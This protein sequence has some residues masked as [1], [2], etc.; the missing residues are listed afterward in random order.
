ILMAAL[1]VFAIIQLGIVNECSTEIAEGWLPSTRYLGDFRAASEQLRSR[2]FQHNI[3]TDAAELA[4]LEKKMDETRQEADDALKNYEKILSGEEDRKLFSEMKQSWTAYLE[5]HE[6][7]FLAASRANDSKKASEVLDGD[8]KKQFDALRE[9]VDKV[10]QFNIAGGTAASA[11]GDELFAS[12]RTMT[13]GAILVALV[14]STSLATWLSRNISRGVMA[15][16]MAARQIAQTDLPQLASCSQSIAEGDLTKN[17]AVTCQPVQVKSNDEIGDMARSFNDM[18]ARLRETGDAFGKMTANLRGTIGTVASAAVSLTEASQQLAAASEQSGAAA[19]QIATTIQEVAKGNQDQSASVQETTASVDQLGRAID[20]IAKGSQN[21]SRAVEH[22]AASVTQL[23]DSI[24][25]ANT[26]SKG[27][28]AAG[29]EVTSAARNGAKSVQS[30]AEGITAIKESTALAASKIQE[31]GA[32]SDQIGSI[33]ETIDDIAEQTNLL[34][35]NAAIEAARA[36]EHG[37]GFAVV[38]DEVRKLAERSSKSTKEIAELIGQVQKATHEAV[39]AMEQGGK[40]VEHGALQSRESADAISSVLAAVEKTNLEVSRI[41]GALLEMETA[42]GQVVAQMDSVSSVVEETSVFTKEM[43]ASSGQVTGAIEKIAAVSEQTS[44]S[45]EEVSASAEEMSAQV[46]EMVAESQ[47]LAQMAEGLQAEVARF[48]LEDDAGGAEV[49]LRRRK[50][51]WA[52]E[53]PR[54]ATAPRRRAEA[55]SRS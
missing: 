45:A 44:A 54:E 47:A 23:N 15:V 27:L 29:D 16:A 38:A 35:L 3:A 46:E 6:K 21:Q 25:Q 9:N 10:T 53:T 17:L 8:M 14:I 32:Y 7:R 49:S 13:I 36:G 39:S 28:S 12:S 41:A 33:V 48:K 4:S 43:A 34:A 42:S 37:R 30:T 11:R 20:Q 51:D 26:A 2:E 55:V 22:A 19:Q 18:I 31:L 5:T 24:Q 50:A 52:P 40:E 1:G